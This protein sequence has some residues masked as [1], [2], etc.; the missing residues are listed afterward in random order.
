MVLVSCRHW[1]RLIHLVSIHDRSV[2]LHR[3]VSPVC[4]HLEDISID[5]GVRA[6]HTSVSRVRA[7]AR[8]VLASTGREFLMSY[9][10]AYHVSFTTKRVVEYLLL[11]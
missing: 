3:A 1:W 11:I 4:R 7:M 6:R 2:L 5:V 9:L 10:R 8:F